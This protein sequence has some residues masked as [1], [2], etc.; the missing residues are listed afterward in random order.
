MKLERIEMA[1]G[2]RW[3]FTEVCMTH[4]T[5]LECLSKSRRK[6]GRLRIQYVEEGGMTGVL[7]YI[8]FTASMLA[9]TAFYGYQYW[10]GHNRQYTQPILNEETGEL[11]GY[12]S[13][14]WTSRLARLARVSCC[15]M[16]S[17]IRELCRCTGRE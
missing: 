11:V 8:V 17:Y 2:L 10:K 3:V 12:S 6:A 9:L 1:V 14:S 4:L 7:V 16:V 15:D 13:E 5:L